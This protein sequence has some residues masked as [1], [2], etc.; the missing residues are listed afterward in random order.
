MDKLFEKFSCLQR[1][2]KELYG[3]EYE[4][5][6]VIERISEILETEIYYYTEKKK[7]LVQQ[8]TQF[9]IKIEECKQILEQTLIEK[10]K[11]EKETITDIF[12]AKK[13][14]YEEYLKLIEER[15]SV[16][17]ILEKKIKELLKRNKEISLKKEESDF[18][19][20]E[21]DFSSKR[22]KKIKEIFTEL[23]E[24]TLIIKKRKEKNI[25]RIIILRKTMPFF[26][27]SID[28]FLEKD[29]LSF[30]E[31]NSSKENK[32][33]ENSL[34]D[35][36]IE[37]L[38]S[39]EKRLNEILEKR[40]CFINK[41]VNILK[42]RKE[43][44]FLYLPMEKKCFFDNKEKTFSVES[45]DIFELEKEIEKT[46]E[47]FLK[48][49]EIL[50]NKIKEKKTLLVSDDNKENFEYKEPT[51]L[52]YETLIGFSNSV[53][54][55]EQKIKKINEIK[56]QINER[57]LFIKKIVDFEEKASDPARLFQS[58]FR[59]IEEERFRRNAV[60][61]LNRKEDKLLFLLQEYKEKFL[62]DFIYKGQNLR[63][64]IEK[65]RNTRKINNKRKN[66]IKPFTNIKKKDLKK[67][68]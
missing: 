57:N 5:E 36:E 40:K 27:S 59:L 60:P 64:E 54:I 45:K 55:I 46:D 25:S 61:L 41:K 12:K 19:E 35:F 65:E 67:F 21:N 6:P 42:E 15:R 33:E 2:K 48:K 23:E 56:I 53:F 58:S 62:N 44:I 26:I 9:D 66:I 8:I 10:K 51:E 30:F 31:E 38:E 1:I 18:F 32:E 24:K 29:F 13:N 50:F 68:N 3:Q 47:L 28:G 17:N 34:M 37:R 11:T 4:K 49:K 16:W 39:I 43:F 14:I 7:D 22:I 63:L 52:T 20:K